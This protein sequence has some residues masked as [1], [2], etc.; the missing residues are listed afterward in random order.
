[1]INDF[2]K[3]WHNDKKYQ[4][5]IKLL[6]YGIFILLATIYALS[7]NNNIQ[8]E[9]DNKD[10]EKDN[11]ITDTKN[12]DI[13][14]IPDEYHY[15]INVVI[16]DKTI[17]YSGN[18]T[19]NNITIMKKIDNNITNY[20]YKNNDYY[21]ENEGIYLKTTKEEVYD[22]VNINY[23][24]LNTINEYLK[25]SHKNNNQYI[26]YLKDIILENESDDYFIILVNDNEINIDYTPLEK[27]INNNIE[28]YKVHIKIEEYKEV[29]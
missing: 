3:K 24:N 12:I 8:N 10:V 22:I 29:N 2:L 23:I 26:V 25:T 6:L 13:I 5:K 17:E 19:N 18:K 11:L 21:I 16:N 15:I 14:N 7:L 20:I 27:I 4:A 28:K 1:M 9:N